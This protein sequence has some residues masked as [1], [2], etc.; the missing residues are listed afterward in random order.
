M[1][2]VLA[3]RHADTLSSV[4]LD[5]LATVASGG[6]GASAAIRTQAAWLWLRHAKRTTS[7]IDTLLGAASVAVPTATIQSTAPLATPP[8]AGTP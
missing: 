4:D 5:L 1:I 7:A 8:K 2:S 3:A 6:T